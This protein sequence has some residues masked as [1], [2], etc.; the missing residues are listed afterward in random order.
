MSEDI[1]TLLPATEPIELPEPNPNGQR[2][3]PERVADRIC[4]V[5]FADG[6]RDQAPFGQD[7]Y[8]FWGLNRLHAV[9]PDKPWTRWFELH[10]LAMYADDPQH[11]KFLHDFQGPVYIRPEDMGVLDIPN[12]VPFPKARI[13]ERYP[14]YFTN[15]VSWLIAMAIEMFDDDAE[16]VKALIER[17]ISPET[18]SEL[19]GKSALQTETL[20]LM[21]KEL[22]VYGVDMA[23]DHV[24]QAEY[25]EQRPSCELFLGVASASGIG[26]K[27]PEGTDLLRASHLY[28]F[29]DPGP[30]HSKKSARFMELGQRKETIKGQLGQLE[31][32]SK[33]LVASL[34]QLDGAMQ[35]INYD[36]RNL[37]PAQKE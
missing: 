12:A 19:L 9:M 4:I 2:P 24:M 36:L 15:T 25:A 5:G 21:E 6:H 3:I 27:M 23:Q 34:N 26:V 35:E 31:G 14:A 11:Q 18:V 22:H 33:H 10:D 37:A 16:L 32:Q 1:A 13:L 20:T 29:E 8:E 28:G 7:G 17:G 30:Y